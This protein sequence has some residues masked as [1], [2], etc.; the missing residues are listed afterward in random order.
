M[1]EL[2]SPSKFTLGTVQ[3]GM[4]Y[5]MANQKGKPSQE[6][7]FQVLDTAWDNG[8]RS[9]DTAVAYGDSEKIIGEYIREEQKPFFIASKFGLKGDNPKAQLLEQVEHTKKYLG[10]VDL[11]MFHSAE[12]LK[13]YGHQLEETLLNLK[14]TGVT[15]S[16]GAS[17]YEEKDI[18]TFLSYEWLSAIQMPMSIL[19]TR[20]IESGLLDELQKRGVQVFVRSVFFQGLL[21]MEEIPEKYQFLYPC[22]QELKEVASAEQMSLKELAVAFIRD[23]PAVNSVVLGCETAQQVKDNSLMMNC[24]EISAQGKAQILG[25]GRRIPSERAMNIVLGREV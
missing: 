25:I 23:L 17:I 24:K 18:E 11:Y 7:A 6:E 5:G 19:D 9:L 2:K 14:E 3:L 4:N 10:S 12:Q 15:E 8:V 20:I 21:C 1:N 22:L 16:L 13:V